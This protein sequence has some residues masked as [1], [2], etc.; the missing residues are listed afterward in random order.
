M[1]IGWGQM[2]GMWFIR[3]SLG[4]M[5]K[6]IEMEGYVLSWPQISCKDEKYIRYFLGW[7]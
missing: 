7:K 3:I 6:E 4:K 1:S 5:P 2:V